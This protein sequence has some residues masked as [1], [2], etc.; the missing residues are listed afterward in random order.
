VP[1]VL[2]PVTS[3]HGVPTG[4]AASYTQPNIVV[5]MSDD[6]RPNTF[7]T[8]PAVRTQL[9]QKGAQYL[10]LSPTS[11]CCPSRTSFLSGQFSHT[12][13]VYNNVDRNW[14]GW[15]QF[16][17]SGY[18]DQN[19]ATELNASGYYTGMI[20]KYLNQ[21]NRAPDGFVPPG[22]DVFRAIYSDDGQGGGRYYDYELRGTHS[23]ESFGHDPVDYSTD[24]LADRAVRFLK[25]R[26]TDQPFFLM[27]TPYAPHDPFTPAPRDQGS[28][29]PSTRYDNPAVNEADMSDKPTFYQDLPLISRTWIDRAQDQ[30]GESLRAVDLAVSR[31]LRQLSGLMSNTLVIYTSDQGVMWG[32]HRLTG[33]YRPYRWATEYPLIMRWDDHIAVGQTGQM[34]A[35]VD[36]A[37]TILD[38]AGIVPSWSME[39]RSVFDV[40]GTSM[41]LEG[42]GGVGY[43]GWCGVRQRNWLYVDWSGDGGIE[44]YDYVHDPYEVNNLAGDPSFAT[45]QAELASLTAKL[46]SPLPPGY[47]P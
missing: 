16:H 17:E 26:P 31:I 28:W 45:K 20:G 9:I 35:N 46:C 7:Q 27:F 13:G 12:T 25:N 1:L 15:P 32:E 5:I 2:V 39:G 18:E 37:A 4:S 43:P 44:M 11:A 23:T 10:G 19:I 21:W 29:T 40:Q 30:T 41:V 8:M 38:A 36:M 47:L 24:V 22:W 33:K 14:G 42:I 34:V 3:A 6:Q